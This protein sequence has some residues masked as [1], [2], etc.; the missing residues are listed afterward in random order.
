[1]QRHASLMIV[2]LSLFLAFNAPQAAQSAE[3]SFDMAHSGIYFDV[4]HI[5]STVR[6]RFNDFAGTFSFDPQDLSGS[7]IEVT[8]QTQSI[9]TQITKRDNHLRSEEFFAVS[10]Y[11]TMTFKSKSISHDGGNNYRVVGDLTVKDVTKEIAV[12][13]IFHGIVESPFQKGK[14]IA[15]FD[16]RFTIDRLEYH[17]GDGKFVKMGVVG[18]DVDVIISIEMISDKSL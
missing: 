3:W 15:G 2:I 8:V 9:D 17:I 4:P 18:K 6:G 11:P 1:M 12:P 10:Q 7:N 13:F 5:Y 14:Q 16:A